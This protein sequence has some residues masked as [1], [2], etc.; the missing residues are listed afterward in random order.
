MKRT[1]YNWSVKYQYLTES[2][3]E[4]RNNREQW[5]YLHKQAD[6]CFIVNFNVLQFSDSKKT[7]HY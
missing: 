5:K 3:V 1:V 6:C 2:K 7:T 4:H